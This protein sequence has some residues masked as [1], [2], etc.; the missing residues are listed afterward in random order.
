M[1]MS[2][3]GNAARAVIY[4]RCSTDES[5]QDTENQLKELRQYVGAFGWSYDEVAE[6]DSGFKGTQPKLQ[7]ILEQIKH[8][9]YTVLLVHD[10]SRFSRQSPSKVNRLLDTI[11]ERDRCRFIS[12]QEGI[13]SDN[14]LTWNVVRPLFAYFAN[15][16][17]RN[18]SEKIKLGIKTKKEKGSYRGG[19][20]PKTVDVERIKRL[21]LS[22]NRYGWRRLT[23]AYNEG[24]PDK[25]QVE[26]KPIEK[27][28]SKT[29]LHW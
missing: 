4:A 21:R 12:R 13:D 25:K 3:K 8:G 7:K 28:M 6:Y 29:L 18:L 17:S 24:L 1:L 20:P 15:I 2:T 11:V 19:R 23:Q 27:G 5:K 26:Y 22:N 14:E 10:L 9:K 16:Y